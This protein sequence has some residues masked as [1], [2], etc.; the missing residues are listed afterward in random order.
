MF[1]NTMYRDTGLKIRTLHV[2]DIRFPTSL[3][4]HGSDAMH[5]D[6][7]YSCTYVIIYTEG[8]VEGHGL[9]FTIGHGNEIVVAAVKSLSPLVVGQDADQ[10]FNDFACFWRKLTSDS[11]LRWIGP[12]KGVIHL[13]T[14]AIINALWDLWANLQQ[15]PLWKLLVDMEPE[16][17]VS[18]IDFRYISDVVTKE[19]AVAM[20]KAMET[21]KEEREEQMKRV[22]YPAYTTQAGWLGYSNEHVKTLCSQYLANGF[23]AFK[24]K[25]GQNLED[26][27]RRCTM[28]RKII[29]WDNKL[30]VDANQVWDIEQAIEWMKQLAEFKPLW[31]EEP[32]SPDDILGH[33]T[34]SKALKPLG[35]GVATGEMCCNRVM[36]KQFL[37]ARAMQ[38]CQIDSCRIGGVNE[39]LSV[40]FMAKKLGV[41]VCPHAGGVGLCEM[42]QHLQIFDYICLTGTTEGRMIEYTNQQHEHF[43]NPIKVIHAHYI[44]PKMPGY[45]TV[46]KPDS[47]EAYEYPHG[48]K[49]Q[50]MFAK[51]LFPDPTKQNVFVCPA[52]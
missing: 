33:A 3:G 50:E 4:S 31:I 22:G 27:R 12:E 1:G 13:A 20:L 45:S 32:T 52:K 40:Y 26:D 48:S 49:W 2:R 41:P 16:K 25:V 10:I 34:I 9:T 7:N 11:Q 46:M 21:G 8:D 15:K 35:I 6:C 29:G 36:F 44:A 43:E 30:M 24:V 38:Y 28:V 51:G 42:V 47:V 39:V 5:V 37:Q 23:T 18:T 19:E 14:A 17:L